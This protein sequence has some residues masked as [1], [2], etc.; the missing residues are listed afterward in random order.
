MGIT[1]AKDRCQELRSIAG[2]PSLEN[3]PQYEIDNIDDFVGNFCAYLVSFTTDSANRILR[4]SG[5]GNGLEAWRRLPSEYDPT[6]SM[7]L[8]VVLQQIQNPPRCQRVEDLGS[9]LEDW[10]SKKRQHDI[11]SPTGTDGLARGDV[12]RREPVTWNHEESDHSESNDGS[13]S[14]FTEQSKFFSDARENFTIL[15]REATLEQSHVPHRTS[16]RET[17]CF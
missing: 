17:R 4:N 14:G 11:C 6:S 16:V 10:L 7:R 2:S 15:R 3:K 8:V 5:E 13:D 12:L 1:T 9:A